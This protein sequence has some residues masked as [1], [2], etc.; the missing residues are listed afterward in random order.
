V[1]L[2]L[3]VGAALLLVWFFP[4]K[5]QAGGSALADYDGGGTDD[6]TPS[7]PADSRVVV[8]GLD[9]TPVDWGADYDWSAV[10][11]G[12][13]APIASGRWQG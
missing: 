1:R 10:P 13:E 8:G 12:I 3:I 2:L 7:L 4:R 5:K 11:D 6:S 9:A